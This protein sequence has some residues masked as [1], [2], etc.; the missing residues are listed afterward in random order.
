MIFISILYFLVSSILYCL[1]VPSIIIGYLP[2]ILTMGCC[3][4]GIDAGRDPN[5]ACKWL[6][7]PCLKKERAILNCM[8]W[9]LIL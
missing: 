4:D 6:C 5:G 3:L 7:F 9:S 2:S 1:N 8:V